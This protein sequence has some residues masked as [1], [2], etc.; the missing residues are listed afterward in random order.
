MQTP[1]RDDKTGRAGTRHKTGS[2]SSEWHGAVIVSCDV[3]NST[4]AYSKPSATPPP[5]CA[6]PPGK[7]L[8]RT[9]ASRLNRQVG[10]NKKSGLVRKNAVFGIRDPRSGKTVRWGATGDVCVCD[11]DYVRCEQIEGTHPHSCGVLHA[12]LS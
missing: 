10:Q 8:T 11:G 9:V 6:L 12:S 4:R 3:V 5:F 7:V 2:N 1:M